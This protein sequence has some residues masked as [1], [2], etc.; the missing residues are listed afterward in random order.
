MTR[1]NEEHV[2]K[3]SHK[4]FHHIYGRDGYVWE[5][6]STS[7]AK[8]TKVVS[9]KGFYHKYCAYCGRQALPIQGECEKGRGFFVGYYDIGHCCV[10]KGAMDEVE[11][12]DQL[13][14]LKKKHEQELKELENLKPKMNQE[15]ISSLVKK[16][17]QEK[18][19]QLEKDLQHCEKYGYMS[20]S[21]LTMVGVT[22]VEGNKN[23]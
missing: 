4:Y 1:R 5:Y 15:V 21:T 7:G 2:D 13:N 3:R 17:F 14:E 22:I 20:E 12:E 10:C 11:Y 23:V 9:V 8:P 16:S 19:A 18:H 6:S